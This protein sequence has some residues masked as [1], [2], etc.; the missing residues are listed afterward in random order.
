MNL[1]ST[2]G[3]YTTSAQKQ[4]NLHNTILEKE[5]EDLLKSEIKNKKLDRLKQ[6]F[7][8]LASKN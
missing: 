1:T 2:D 4:F 7:K 5:N 8:N 3:F 6:A